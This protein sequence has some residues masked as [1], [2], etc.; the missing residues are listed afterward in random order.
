MFYQ[1][2][3]SFFFFFFFLQ[4]AS[5]LPM[6]STRLEP[7]LSENSAKYNKIVPNILIPIVFQKLVETGV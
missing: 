2:F 6:I 5:G 3:F 1:T 7:N 4:A